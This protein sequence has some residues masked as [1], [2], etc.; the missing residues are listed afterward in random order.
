MRGISFGLVAIALTLGTALGDP[1]G[2][3]A[4]YVEVKG[5]PLKP[6]VGAQLEELLA[7]A[8]AN[9]PE[10][11]IAEA[12]LREA[13]AE[14]RRSRMGL[15]QRI[16]DLQSTIE[17]QKQQVVF[18]ESAAGTATQQRKAN[19]I[20]DSDFKNALKQ[21]AEAKAILARAE[22]QLGMLCSAPAEWRV[23]QGFPLGGGAGGGAGHQDADP[24]A[25]P[26]RVPHQAMAERIRK[27]LDTPVKSGDFKEAALA[28]VL[29]YY[30]ELSKDVPIVI[31]LGGRTGD[32]ISLTLNKELPLGSHLQALQDLAPGLQFSV[33]DYGI[34]ATCDTQ[35]DDAISLLD[36]WQGK[37][38]RDTPK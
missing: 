33:R 29:G 1:P 34:L 37:A 35:P 5:V 11:Q 23:V 18:A 16:I 24:D 3:E 8:I 31:A 27:A 30:R 13:E 36:F 25:R 4:Q 12:K 15:M 21:L 14:V 22:A 26:V 28:D 17:I 2:K 38:K 32:P 10:V 9:S 7:K 20:S 6:G 19:A